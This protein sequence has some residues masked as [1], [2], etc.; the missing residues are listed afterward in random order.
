VTKEDTVARGSEAAEGGTKAFEGRDTQPES[1]SD[2]GAIYRENKDA[3]KVGESI[4]SQGNRERG[5]HDEAGREADAAEEREQG[6]V[7]APSTGRLSSGVTPSDP[8]DD[9]SPHLPT[10]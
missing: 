6:R 3:E 8:I 4:N 7:S 9:E 5:M 2:G 1:R 10:P